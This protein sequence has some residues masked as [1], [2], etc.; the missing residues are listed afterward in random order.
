MVIVKKHSKT[1]YTI[2]INIILITNIT[3]T[4]KLLITYSVLHITWQ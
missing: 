3:V 4:V 1:M 2:S